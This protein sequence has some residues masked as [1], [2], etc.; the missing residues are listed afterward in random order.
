[1]AGKI[2]YECS[3]GVVCGI[4][5]K[6]EHRFTQVKAMDSVVFG[7]TLIKHCHR[8]RLRINFNYDA[9]RLAR[10]LLQPSE[11]NDVKIQVVLVPAGHY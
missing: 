5:F 2:N 7:R 4:R 8:I 6:K 1:M 9:V 11:F 3:F 10:R